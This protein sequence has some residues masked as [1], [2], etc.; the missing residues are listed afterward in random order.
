MQECVRRGKAC[1]LAIEARAIVDA[2]K[3]RLLASAWSGRPWI[4]AM[5]GA[6]PRPYTSYANVELTGETAH[7]FA[8][9]RYCRFES[10]RWHHSAKRALKR[11]KLSAGDIALQS[12]PVA[13]EKTQRGRLLHKNKWSKK[14]VE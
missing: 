1:C 8:R 3:D 13:D 12:L 6:N 4:G 7:P 2:N 9:S 14:E 5:R 10:C 11:E